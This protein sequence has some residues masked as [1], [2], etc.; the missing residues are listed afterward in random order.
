VMEHGRII[1][2]FANAE[3]EANLDK[4]HVYLGV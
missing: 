4:L 3:L 1:D 2:G